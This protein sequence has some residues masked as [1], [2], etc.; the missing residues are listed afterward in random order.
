MKRILALCALCGFGF[1]LTGCGPKI[2]PP[3]TEAEQKKVESGVMDM[4]KMMEAKMGQ[5]PAEGDPVVVPAGAGGAGSGD[6]APA[7]KGDDAAEGG[8]DAPSE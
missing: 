1:V 8:G 2:A 5:A 7:A 4:T 6:A 3:A